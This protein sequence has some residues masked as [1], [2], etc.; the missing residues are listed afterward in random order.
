MKAWR[1]LKKL[2][3]ELWILCFATLVNRLGTMALPFLVLYLT[4]SLGFSAARA[5]ATLA[6]YGGVSLFVGPVAG[7]LSDRFGALRLMEFSLVSSGI[8]LLIFPLAH[9]WPAVVCVTALFSVTNEAFRPANLSLVGELGPPDLQ[10]PA[11]A[12]SRWAINLGMSVGPAVGGF[13]AQFSFPSLFI[14]DGTTTI[15]AAGILFFSPFHNSVKALEAKKRESRNTQGQNKWLLD[16]FFSDSDLRILILGV[17]PVALVFFQHES[18]M[19]L[20]LV[21]N[22]HFSESTY[23][24]LFTLNTVLI[25]FLEIPLNSATAHWPYRRTLVSGALLFALGFG[26]LALAHSYAQVA[27]TVVIWTFGEMILFPGMSAYISDLAPE[28][29]RG[30]YMGLYMMAFSVA[31]MVGPWLGTL[32]LERYGATFLWVGTLIVG[33]ISA[34]IFSLTNR[35]RKTV[36]NTDLQ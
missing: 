9:S 3:R 4:R 32:T 1:D 19:A 33:L 13:L 25:I 21:R 2:P 12:L 31:L 27:A 29:K 26:A 11:F 8:S 16:A 6:V 22:L 35:N 18:A 23:G 5:G 10:K 7:K 14:V 34:S 36:V 17:L 30:E 28:G 15:I 20:F 24:L